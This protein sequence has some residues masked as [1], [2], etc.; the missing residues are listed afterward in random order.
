MER[1]QTGNLIVTPKVLSIS[2][3][4]L[5]VVWILGPELVTVL[6]RSSKPPLRASLF[7]RPLPRGEQPAGTTNPSFRQFTSCDL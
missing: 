4:E 3:D 6:Q 5:N 7:L 2:T 1:E